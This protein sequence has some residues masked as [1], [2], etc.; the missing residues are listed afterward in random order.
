MRFVCLDTETSGMSAE[1]NICEFAWS[2]VD[3]DCNIIRSHASLIDPECPI[4]PGASGV[5]GI[6][7]SKVADAPTMQEYLAM[8]EH[9]FGVEDHIMAIAHSWPFDKRFIRKHLDHVENGICTLKLARKIYTD[10]PDFKMQTLRFYLNL[11]VEG[12]A[13]SAAGDV[14]VLV[15]LIRR[16]SQ[17][18]NLDLFGLYELANQP[19]L[20]TKMGFGKYKGKALKELPDSYIK[21]L[22]EL[23]DLSEDMRY[24]LE[25]M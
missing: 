22:L 6:V 3:P 20:I 24:S 19:T 4:S 2:E 17:D 14:A 18:T 9:P 8:V 21:W 12:A 7:Y 13:H 11:D 16:M 10:S 5:H 25:R 23:P 1:D 15:S